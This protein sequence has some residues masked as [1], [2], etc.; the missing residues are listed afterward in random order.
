MSGPSATYAWVEQKDHMFSL[1]DWRKIGSKMGGKWEDRLN[2]LFEPLYDDVRVI[3]LL[4]E[5]GRLDSI[6]D[7]DAAID[8]YRRKTVLYH[9]RKFVERHPEFSYLIRQEAVLRE[10]YKPEVSKAIDEMVPE[11][12][13]EKAHKVKEDDFLDKHVFRP[14]AFGSTGRYNS[15]GEWH[16]YRYVNEPL[17]L[18]QPADLITAVQKPKKD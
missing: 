2:S 11:E 18:T 5:S 13:G 9:Q 4:H 8:D 1:S 17:P 12:V 16:T 7:L 15:K 10:D 6:E 14:C 3:E